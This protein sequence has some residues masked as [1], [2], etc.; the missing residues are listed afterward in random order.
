MLSGLATLVYFN[1]LLSL[2]RTCHMR[3]QKKS[4]PKTVS[5]ASPAVME[6]RP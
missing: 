3:T 6:G 2:E 4:A 5:P 1:V